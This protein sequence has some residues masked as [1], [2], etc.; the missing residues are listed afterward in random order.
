DGN[1]DDDF[2]IRPF[3][4]ENVF[5]IHTEKPYCAKLEWHRYT[6]GRAE[7][8]LA[9]IREHLQTADELELWHVWLDDAETPVFKRK[10]YRL[11]ELTTTVL[12]ELEVVPLTTDP[13]VHYCYKIR[14][15]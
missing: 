12:K 4:P 13:L 6:E 14:K 8:I 9:Y 1:F 2:S 3:P 15:D 7:N 11:S 10:A 5:G